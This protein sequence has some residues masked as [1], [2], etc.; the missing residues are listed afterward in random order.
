MFCRPQ[1]VHCVEK[2]LVSEHVTGVL[3]KGLASLLDAPRIAD[4]TL[5]Y[6]LFSRVK[7]GLSE[8]CS[9]FN[10]YIKVCYIYFIRVSYFQ[11]FCKLVFFFSLQKKGRTIVIDPEKDKSMVQELLEFKDKLD[12]IVLTCFNKNEKFINSLKEAFE[13]FINQRTNKPAELIGIFFFIL[14]YYYLAFIV[15]QFNL[16]FS[17]ICR[18]KITRWKQRSHGR[19]T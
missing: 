11:F 10:S 16:N 7:N 5:L 17:K 19:R 3:S 13:H 6:N 9:H 18:C 8:L 12:Y 1:L 14:N 15:S 4:L 2:Q